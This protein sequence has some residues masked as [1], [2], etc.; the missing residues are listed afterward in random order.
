MGRDLT[1]LNIKDSYEGLVQISGSQLTD[2][3]GSLIPSLEVSASFVVSASYAET[4]TSAS[5]AL[6]S[7]FASSATQLH[8]LQ[9][10]Y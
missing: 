2:G 9:Q 4:S 8:L 10:H 7:D 1:N 3:T 5:H 6:V